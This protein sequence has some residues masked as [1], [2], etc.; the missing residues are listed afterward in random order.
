MKKIITVTLEYDPLPDA[1]EY[2]TSLDFIRHDL[3]CEIG[4]CCHY[5]EVLNVTMEDAK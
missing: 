1:G 4:G 3:E 2:E 5:Y